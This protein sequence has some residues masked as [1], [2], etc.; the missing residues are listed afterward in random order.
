MMK[1]IYTR[2][3][4]FIFLVI[5]MS[6][7]CKK[8]QSSA[9]ANS[10]PNLPTLTTMTVESI[11]PITANSGG[12]ITSNGAGDVIYRGVCWNT[13][14]NPTIQNA[15]TEDGAGNG[16]FTSTITGL[17]QDSTYYVRAY[18]I[19]SYG[20]AY[21]NQVKFTTPLWV[22]APTV[23]TQFITNVTMNNALGGGSVTSTG[24]SALTACGVCWSTGSTPTINDNKTSGPPDSGSFTS[25]LTN[26]SANIKYYVRAYAINSNAG[27]GYGNTISF[28]TRAGSVT[29]IDGNVYY[30]NQ[31]GTQTWMTESLRTTKFSNG[32]S[33]PEKESVDDWTSTSSAAYC[34]YP[35]FDSSR[36]QLYGRYYNWLAVNDSRNICPAGWHVPSDSE[37]QLLLGYLGGDS[38]AGGKMK[39]AGTLH[40]GPPN[41]G[42][43]NES[44]FTALPSG[45]RAALGLFYDYLTWG[46]FWS[47]TPVP[48]AM[49]HAFGVY[50]GSSNCYFDDQFSEYFGASVRC[51]KN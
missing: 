45:E 2:S 5:G 46:E 27:I 12:T 14:G 4:L 18:A 16:I 38:L 21:G 28:L 6:N 13:K 29:D 44:G 47:S 26:L 8:D 51:I 49:A 48:N 24:S 30:Y 31:I 42:A 39:E 25:Q 9:A 1:K 43:T 11:T 10:N 33:I 22:Q 40:W 17:H 35:G 7:S 3:F 32:V 19:N 37:W 15:H 20:I 50:Y 36:V 41:T 34:N 23:T